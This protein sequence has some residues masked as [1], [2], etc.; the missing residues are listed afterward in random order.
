MGTTKFILKG[1]ALTVSVGHRLYSCNLQEYNLCPTDSPGP[2]IS[3]TVG[4]Q[5]ETYSAGISFLPTYAGNGPSNKTA[6][7]SEVHATGWREYTVESV[8]LYSKDNFL[9]SWIL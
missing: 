4:F 5:K 3:V 9:L 8:S 7:T 2:A 6:V 1:S